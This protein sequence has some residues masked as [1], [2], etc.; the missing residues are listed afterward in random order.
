[1]H[2]RQSIHA[3]FHHGSRSDW[4]VN[5]SDNRR[6]FSIDDPGQWIL[7]L[8]IIVDNRP[9]FQDATNPQYTRT[10]PAASGNSSAKLLLSRIFIYRTVS[11]FRLELSRFT[12]FPVTC[13]PPL[14]PPKTGLCFPIPP[15]EMRYHIRIVAPI[16]LPAGR[17]ANIDFRSKNSPA[18]SDEYFLW[19]RIAKNFFAVLII[20]R[21][22]ISIPCRAQ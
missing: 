14:S 20:P 15:T 22:L 4:P 11:Y 18:V 8:L 16:V 1:V 19:F 6:R 3:A 21:H 17:P 12:S 13:L 5:E 2:L 7:C 10:V 9:V